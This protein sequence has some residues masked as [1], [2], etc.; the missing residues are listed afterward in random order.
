MQLDIFGGVHYILNNISYGKNIIEDRR[1]DEVSKLVIQS[2][3][4]IATIYFTGQSKYYF[5]L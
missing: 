1:K 4:S 5:M 2:I 3:N